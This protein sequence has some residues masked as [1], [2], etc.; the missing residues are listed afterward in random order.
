MGGEKVHPALQSFVMFKSES[1]GV[2]NWASEVTF[3]HAL[4]GLVLSSKGQ[5][6]EGNSFWG[7]CPLIATFTPYLSNRGC[8]PHLSHL[9]FTR[10]VN[11]NWLMTGVVNAGRGGH[12]NEVHGDCDQGHTSMGRRGAGGGDKCVLLEVKH[13]WAS[14][15]GSWRKRARE[16]KKAKRN[17][18]T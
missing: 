12:S 16:G 10:R 6:S 13:C 18:R 8:P 15:L 17:H 1:L 14:T 2:W 5:V 7:T 9:D 4:R 11:G 3:Q